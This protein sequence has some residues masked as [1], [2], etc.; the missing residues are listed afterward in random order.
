MHPAIVVN[1]AI[2]TK[3][4]KAPIVPKKDNKKKKN[5]F[6]LDTKQIGIKDEDEK[7]LKDILGFSD[8]NDSKDKN[9]ILAFQ[10]YLIENLDVK[11]DEDENKENTVEKRW[12]KLS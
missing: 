8:F 6:I 12:E 2:T 5:A 7:I 1:G 10:T 11:E 9:T 3:I 4:P